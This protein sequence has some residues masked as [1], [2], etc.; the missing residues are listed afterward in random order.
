MKP[1]AVF[2]FPLVCFTE[3]ST[4][5]W[6]CKA[7]SLPAQRIAYFSFINKVDRTQ[8]SRKRNDIESTN[9]IRQN[10]IK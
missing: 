1:R 5:G 2:H 7:V 6:R 9:K 4:T 8:L 10:P 3:V